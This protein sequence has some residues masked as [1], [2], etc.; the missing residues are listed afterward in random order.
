MVDAADPE[1]E[2]CI[3]VVGVHCSDTSRTGDAIERILCEVVTGVLHR[4]IELRFETWL[5][6]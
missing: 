6:G 5:G 2:G 4:A 1:E 3:A